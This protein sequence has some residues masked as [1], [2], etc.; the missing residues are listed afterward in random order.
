MKKLVFL[1]FTLSSFTLLFSQHLPLQIGNQWHYAPGLVPSNYYAAIAT[2]TVFINNNKYFKIEYW[3]PDSSILY[4]THYDRIEGDSLYYSYI[5][6]RD[7]LVFN[8]NWPD[9]F[10]YSTPSSIDSNCIDLMLVL[11]NPGQVWGVLTDLYTVFGGFYCTGMIDTAWTLSSLTYSKYFGGI[12][13]RDGVLVGA[14]INGVTYGTLYPLPVELL[15]FSSSVNDNDITL[16]WITATETNNSGFEIQRNTPLNPLSRGEAEGRDVWENIGFVNGSGTTTETKTY[17]YKDENLAA[18]K[19]QYRLKQIDFDG[20]FEYSNIIEAEILPPAKFSLE[21][22]YPNP[23][24]P[25]TKISWQ[26]PVSSHQ[27]L[28]VY[29]MLGNEIMTLVNEFRIA[30][31]YEVEFNAS[32][33]ASGLYFYQI[34]CEGLTQTKKMI[35][36]R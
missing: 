30:G 16:S 6:G 11:R 34:K 29:D 20:T 5:N 21:Q 23:F 4:W 3:N 12:N 25:S 18:G 33:L 14:L 8:F 27:T 17:S 35:L 36:I 24:N 15:S 1:F 7:N 22:N 13:A 19:Y 32:T 10:I 9:N 31:K 26:S 28:K 2:D